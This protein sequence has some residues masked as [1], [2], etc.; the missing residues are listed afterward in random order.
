[1]FQ[2]MTTNGRAR[3]GRIGG[4]LLLVVLL[5]AVLLVAARRMHSPR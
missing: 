2:G 3:F 5:A 4:V 1:M